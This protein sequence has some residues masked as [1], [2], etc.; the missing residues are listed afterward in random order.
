M[1]QAFNL[2][3]HFRYVFRM[4]SRLQGECAQII[5]RNHSFFP[6]SVFSSID[7]PLK[8]PQND[9]R[10]R[11]EKLAKKI[12]LST[13]EIRDTVKAISNSNCFDDWEP[14]KKFLS[15]KCRM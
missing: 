12:L 15:S 4:I 5:Y 3:D 10:E 9:I 13:R 6:Q 14:H 7:Q 11:I 1:K 2:L 8:S